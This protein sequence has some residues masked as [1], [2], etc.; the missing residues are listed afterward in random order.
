MC[1]F[2]TRRMTYCQE[3]AIDYIKFH[4]PLVLKSW[5]LVRDTEI[6]EEE[7]ISG[8]SGDTDSPEALTAFGQD[9]NSWDRVLFICPAKAGQ[10]KKSSNAYFASLRWESYFGQ[11]WI[12]VFQAVIKGLRKEDRMDGYLRKWPS[13]GGW[14]T[15]PGRRIEFIEFHRRIFSG[16]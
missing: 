7:L 2:L 8:E 1:Q 15:R 9:L 6:A 14:M 11:E 4:R 3:Q 13:G 5:G 16:T 10:I 12:F